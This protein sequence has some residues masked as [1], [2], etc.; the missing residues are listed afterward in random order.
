MET[1]KEFIS[2]VIARAS[3][4][5]SK[6]RT[7]DFQRFISIA[8]IV[9]LV[10]SNSY[11]VVQAQEVP[12]DEVGAQPETTQLSGPESEAV[13]QP[14]PKLPESQSFST[15]AFTPNA[16]LIPHPSC[17][18]K[19]T[20]A[21]PTSSVYNPNSEYSTAFVPDGGGAY[22]S[23]QDINGDGL[24]DFIYTYN[25]SNS[26]GSTLSSEHN[27]CVYL[28]NGSGWEKA[29]ECSAYT[30]VDTSTGNLVRAEYRGDCA[31]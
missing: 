2:L 13:E 24:A 3:L 20:W 17:F 19:T 16:N 23:F 14:G 11:F 15:E 9:A 25:Q 31:G 18:F 21:M 22:R 5:R 8:A 10:I 12:T 29:Y 27:G 30:I 28:H 7:L 4:L 6:V 26:A 1:I